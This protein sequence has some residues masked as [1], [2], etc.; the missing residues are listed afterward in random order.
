MKD[1]NPYRSP[2]DEQIENS[3]LIVSL[4]GAMVFFA[5]NLVCCLLALVL[6]CVIWYFV[7]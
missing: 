3:K 7:G 1:E 6:A 4:A 5:V 2:T